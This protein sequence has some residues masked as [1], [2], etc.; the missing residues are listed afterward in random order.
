MADYIV[1][2]SRSGM[3]FSEA[4][5]GLIPGWAGVARAIIKAGRQNAEFMAKTSR[6]VK[7]DQLGDMGIYSRVVN[8]SIPFPRKQKS[9]DPEAD[10][11]AYE[12]ACAD[13]EMDTGLAVLPEA[14]QICIC[15]SD[16]ICRSGNGIEKVHAQAEAVDAE[17]LRRTN[18]QT[19]AGLYGRSLSEVKEEIARLGRPLA[20]QSIAALDRL[21]SL[22][23][24]A[25]FDEDSFVE[26]E[27]REDAALYRDPRFRAGLVGTL[28]QRVA[29]FRGA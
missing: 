24:E 28:E 23:D 4:M 29:D 9:A 12:R 5:I 14:L 10:R 1:G 8:V 6:E 27:M 16:E 11:K 20:P 26:A 22:Y 21:F 3:C 15:P 19:Y 7:A 2:D 13:N 25:A 17:V 18:P